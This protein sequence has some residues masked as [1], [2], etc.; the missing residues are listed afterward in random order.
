MQPSVLGHPHLGWAWEPSHFYKVR[1]EGQRLVEGRRKRVSYSRR[2]AQ[3]G[4]H[5]LENERKCKEAKKQ[6]YKK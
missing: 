6:L 2:E 3:R 4:I 5:V 1:E